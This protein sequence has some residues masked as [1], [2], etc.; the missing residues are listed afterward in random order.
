VN[1]LKPD[2]PAFLI[3]DREFNNQQGVG[4]APG[5]PFINSRW[6]R[7]AQVI[8]FLVAVHSENYIRA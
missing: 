2:D 7:S 6:Y 8:H 5:S 4:F 3:V 1:R